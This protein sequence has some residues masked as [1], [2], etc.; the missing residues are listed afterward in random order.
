MAA[1]Q[2]SGRQRWLRAAAVALFLVVA[3]PLVP[4]A[5]VVR[6]TTVGLGGH[7]AFDEANG[8]SALDSVGGLTGTLSGGTS[9]IDDGFAAR[10]L[11]FDGANDRVAIPA[12]AVLSSP[13]MTISVWVRADPLNPPT[14]DA[15]ILENGDVGCLGGAYGVLVDGNFVKL[16]FR[17]A[18]NGAFDELVVPDEVKSLTKPLWDGAWHH[19]AIQIAS[20]AWGTVRLYIDGHGAA[21]R[22]YSDVTPAGIDYDGLDTASMALGG[23]AAS[24]G[25]TEAYKG[26][27]DDLRVYGRFVDDATLGSL[28][29]P[30][31]TAVAM[32]A[33][34]SLAV[35]QMAW[36]SADVEPRPWAGTIETV[37]VDRHGVEHL[38][39]RTSSFY[40]AL[41]QPIPYQLFPDVGGDG[42]LLTRYLGSPPW[43][44]SSTQ[45][46]VT[47]SKAVA[48][49]SLRFPT[50][51]TTNDPV[52]IG[53][54]VNPAP[55]IRPSGSVDLYEVVGG[56]EQFIA[57]ETLGEPVGTT[58]A[59]V[60]FNLPARAPGSY[61]FKAYYSGDDAFLP[62]GGENTVEVLQGLQP[63]SVLI[64]D[65][66]AYTTNPIVTVTAPAAGAIGMQITPDLTV[67]VPPVTYAASQ[68]VWM[69]AG[70]YGNDVDGPHSMYVRWGGSL[71]D[72]TTW[73]SD[74]IVLDRIAPSG[75]VS[76]AGG[77]A[78]VT[79]SNVTMAVP[80]TDI[81]SGVSQV[82]LS[83][84]GVTWT[85]RP[86]AAQQTW[87]LSAGLG[88]KTVQV[89]WQDGA[90]NW[91]PA[92]SDAVTV[93]ALPTVVTREAGPNRYATAAAISAGA[94]SPG[95]PVAYVALGT[96]FPDALAAAAAAGYLGGP[97]L[98][99][100]T[101]S[102]PAGTAA[103]LARLKPGRIVVA[104]GISVVSD[105]VL[106]ALD[107]YTTGPVTRQ[108]GPN[109]Y[110]TA[111]AISAGAF[112]PG[113]PVA[114]VALGTNFP[115][116]LAAAAAA[117]YLGGPVLL[118]TTDSI[119]AGTA[120]ELARLK[121]GRIVVA[122]GISVV[123]D[124][125]LAA[126]AAY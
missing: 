71:G 22:Y 106:A 24:C 34:P 74:S 51:T 75:S 1:R 45:V 64:N 121:P 21:G 122:G 26:D 107:P 62:S 102:I 31:S 19:V 59:T 67:D 111:A 40:L 70:W 118:V 15:V 109:R 52:V 110:A 83:N 49:T 53:V 57:S 29:P 14:D 6:A 99:V 120:A 16:R 43:T 61:A 11:Q 125:V 78:A 8:T 46:P 10:A 65:G 124:A 28:E 3:F 108:A 23:A 44:A 5:G 18:W 90:G 98:L 100:T 27:L 60:D 113:V 13:D 79:T 86:Y 81:W 12:D 114:Y 94:F 87:A 35:G 41:P 68:I 80:A 47:I 126:L 77:A 116:A 32:P 25:T 69:A 119:P 101:D 76:I 36:L 96:N 92:V 56:V 66:T 48:W 50:W 30:V 4:L 72:W 115:D 38:L 85:T 123:S 55:D 117:G 2:Q 84:D 39:G 91:S 82:A 112:S 88:T 54:I 97:V 37:F 63:G 33:L 7:W 103:E 73:V 95:V 58:N 93:D 20:G 9:R 17:A 104:G 89:K 105:A 42:T